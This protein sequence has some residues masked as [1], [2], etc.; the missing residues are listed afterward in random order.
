[1]WWDRERRRTK[2]CHH[3]YLTPHDARALSAHLQA[4]FPAM[5]FLS[6]DYWESFVD[7]EA[8][9]RKI[10]DAD[11]KG[12]RGH[13]PFDMEDPTGKPFPYLPSLE[14]SSTEARI[15][16]IEPE[17]PNFA[18]L[19]CLADY[20]RGIWQIVNEPPV[21]LRLVPGWFRYPSR[22]SYSDDPLPAKHGKELILLREAHLRASCPAEDEDARKLM[23]K[24]WRV[25]TKFFSRT[26]ELI[27]CDLNTRQPFD[28][29]PERYFATWVG[30]DAAAWGNQRRHNYFGESEPG[31]EDATCFKPGDYPF[32]P[33]T[34]LA[35]WTRKSFEEWLEEQ[36]AGKT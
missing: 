17:K 35:V 18:W 34:K 12:I 8:H 32:A 3:L 4:A 16:W 19:P 15:G 30:P 36:S 31:Y 10:D 9:Q 29:N 20:R 7:M 14:G 22:L 1:M 25:V 5:R 21:Q 24:L 2:T 33:G 26:S 11:A 6:G 27:M 23:A 28:L 13:I